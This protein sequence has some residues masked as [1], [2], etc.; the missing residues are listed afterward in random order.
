MTEGD[1]SGSQ[2]LTGLWH[3][4]YS[5]PNGAPPNTFTATLS[6]AGGWLSGVIEER[7]DLTPDAGQTIGAAI[8]GRRDGAHVHFL[9]TYDQ[10]TLHRDSVVYDGALNAEGTEIAGRWTIPGNWSGEFMMVRASA[11]PEAMAREVGERV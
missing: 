6:E 7:A 3:G 9:K 10:V 4:R 11:T 5:Y 8:Q 2:S 1:P